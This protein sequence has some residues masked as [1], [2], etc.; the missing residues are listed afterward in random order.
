MET[1]PSPVH[2]MFS[3]RLD[4]EG[5]HKCDLSDI[6]VAPPVFL[7]G[8][9]HTPPKP[10]PAHDAERELLTQTSVTTRVPRHTVDD[11]GMMKPGHIRD[12]GEAEEERR[13]DN[14]TAS[15]IVI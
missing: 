5:Y 7:A 12:A 3:A 6:A 9:W 8:Q 11:I 13:I 2:R 4:F 14:A 15:D 1:T 10:G